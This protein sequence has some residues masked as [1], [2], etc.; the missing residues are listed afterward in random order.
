[1]SSSFCW[2]ESTCVV[3]SVSGFAGMGVC[4]AFACLSAV[5]GNHQIRGDS[6]FQTLNLVLPSVTLRVESEWLRLEVNRKSCC[7]A[8]AV[9]MGV[10]N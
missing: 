1:M 6:C 7:S 3:V 2:A 4:V 10:I 9:E 5:P 8:V